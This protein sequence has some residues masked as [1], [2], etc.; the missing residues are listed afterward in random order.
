MGVLRRRGRAFGYIF[1]SFSLH[2]RIPPLSLTLGKGSKVQRDK[3]F[4]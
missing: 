1:Y 3:G 2:K 4:P